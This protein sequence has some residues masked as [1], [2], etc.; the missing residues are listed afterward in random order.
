MIH[1][2]MYIDTGLFGMND[3]I[4][5]SGTTSTVWGCPKHFKESPRGENG[6]YNDR[7]EFEERTPY[8]ND[9]DLWVKGLSIPRNVLPNEAY[10]GVTSENER[11]LKIPIGALINGYQMDYEVEVYAYNPLLG[12]EEQKFG[13]LQRLATL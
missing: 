5:Q 1:V 9:M 7:V 8:M 13:D 12:D 4:V 2:H 6:E 3:F 10:H 11:H